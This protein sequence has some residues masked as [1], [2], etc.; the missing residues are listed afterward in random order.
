MLIRIRDFAEGTRAPAG[1]FGATV[2]AETPVLDGIRKRIALDEGL[3]ANLL[4]GEVL[5]SFEV[6]SVRNPLASIQ[7]VLEGEVA[8]WVGDCRLPVR[9]PAD[10][11][12]RAILSVTDKRCPFR[13]RAEQGTRIRKLSLAASAGWLAR[14]DLSLA[15]D[16]CQSF[17]AS[18]CELAAARRFFDPDASRIALHSAALALWSEMAARAGD[19]AD[20]ARRDRL[21]R[22]EQAALAPGPMPRL[23]RVAAAGSVSLATMDRMFRE[24]HGVPPKRWIRAARLQRAA[25]DLHSGLP[26]QAVAWRAGYARPAAFSTA[27]RAWSGVLPSEARRGDPAAV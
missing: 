15:P 5:Q 13:A 6:R 22:M 4:D 8:I 2:R 24:V 19:H 26:I 10:G 17:V 1:S 7:L 12:G 9:A 11:V 23:D 14:Y 27:F 16:P 21:H 20:A 25:E 3:N 18:P